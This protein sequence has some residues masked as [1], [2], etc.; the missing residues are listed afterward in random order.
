MPVKAKLDDLVDGIQCQTDE[1]TSY[2][3]RETGECIQVTDQDW[4]LI[5][6]AD[7]D[8]RE[9]EDWEEEALAQVRAI[10]EDKAGRF[11]ELPDAHEVRAWDMMADFAQEQDNAAARA[12]LLRAIE[13]RGAFRRFK[14]LV[15]DLGLSDKW[16][17]F[18]DA[19]YAAEARAWAERHDIEI[20][21]EPSKLGE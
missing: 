18:R 4:E 20:A 9:L 1:G 11:V 6:V 16:Y 7:E 19:R 3:D 10:H 21:D 2:F 12:G 14:D 13:G 17:A 15:I 8:E 5:E